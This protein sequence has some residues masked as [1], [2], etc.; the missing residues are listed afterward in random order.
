MLPGH[1]VL[2][3]STVNPSGNGSFSTLKG[4]GT[5]YIDLE[6]N[7]W[8]DISVAI[9]NDTSSAKNPTLYVRPVA[10]E[11]TNETFQ[12]KNEM[13]VDLTVMFGSTIAD[14]IYSLETATPG[15]GVAWFCKLFPKP[16]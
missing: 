5:Q 10:S 1:K 3:F 8:T 6:G 9:Y 4:T 14:Y 15:A 12:F 7:K 2:F 16:Y 13:C 11:W